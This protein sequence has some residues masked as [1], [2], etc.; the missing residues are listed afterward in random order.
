M[1]KTGYFEESPGVKSSTRLIIATVIGSG[2][3]MCIAMAVTGLMAWWKTPAH[4]MQELVTLAQSVSTL[5]G[6]T[7]IGGGGLKIAHNMTAKD[8]PD[9]QQANGGGQ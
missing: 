3:S 7:V 8:A 6:T 1:E 2:I 5:F 4:S 9:N